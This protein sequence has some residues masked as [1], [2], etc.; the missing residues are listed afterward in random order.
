MAIWSIAPFNVAG[1]SP[2]PCITRHKSRTICSI[3][4]SHW[5]ADPLSPIMIVSFWLSLLRYLTGRILKYNH[6]S[7]P[8]TTLAELAERKVVITGAGQPNYRPKTWIGAD[9]YNA[10]FV[11]P[12]CTIKVFGLILCTWLNGAPGDLSRTEV[13]M[14][15][16]QKEGRQIGK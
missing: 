6:S 9:A 12:N 7:S 16:G 15:I 3:T 1:R 11:T 4:L 10:I 8:F 2:A 5:T 14:E 13:Y